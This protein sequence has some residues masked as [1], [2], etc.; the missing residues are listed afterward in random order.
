VNALKKKDSETAPV[1]QNTK[2]PVKNSGVTPAKKQKSESAVKSAKKT[3]SKVTDEKA[4]TGKAL[5]IK[6][7]DNPAE[8]VL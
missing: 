4:G 3:S 8:K 2:K 7:N 1:K 6:K 5:K